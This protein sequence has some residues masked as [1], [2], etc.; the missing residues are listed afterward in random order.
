MAFHFTG[1]EPLIRDD[2]L[3]IIEAFRPDMNL[4]SVQ[5]NGSGDAL[6]SYTTGSGA[7]ILG[8][9]T[10]TGRAGVF[11]AGAGLVTVGLKL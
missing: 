3:D 7:A 1:G 10:G 11:A 8:D 2:L 9:T 6:Y 4:I 5:T